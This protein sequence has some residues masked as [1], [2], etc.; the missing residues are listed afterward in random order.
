MWFERIFDPLV[1]KFAGLADEEQKAV[2]TVYQVLPQRSVDHPS[3]PFTQPAD[4][5]WV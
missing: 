2:A 1:E 5:G 4:P 3:K